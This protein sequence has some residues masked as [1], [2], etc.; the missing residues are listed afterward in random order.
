MS[1]TFRRFSGFFAVALFGLVIDI[2]IA[3]SLN[4]WLAVPLIWSASVGFVI[5]MVFN[6]LVNLKVTY[7]DR[8]LPVSG[9]GF[10]LYAA[11]VGTGLVVRLLV[12]MVLQWVLPEHL[13]FGL[14]MLIVAA[15]ASLIVNFLVA[16]RWAFASRRTD[17]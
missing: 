13:Q 1:G 12:L 15:G 8:R 7:A 3:W 14:P 5:A 11:S 9:R 17:H 2:G 4:R 6:Y 10:M 16:N